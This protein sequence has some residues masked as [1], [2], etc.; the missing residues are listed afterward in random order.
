MSKFEFK[1]GKLYKLIFRKYIRKNGKVIRPK[2]AK[3]FRIWVPV[4]SAV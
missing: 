2:K 3:S 1:N 4:D